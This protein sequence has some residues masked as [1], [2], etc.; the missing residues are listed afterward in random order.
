MDSFDKLE[1]QKD[2]DLI[3]PQDLKLKIINEPLYHFKS[4][5]KLSTCCLCCKDLTYPL[6]VEERAI[7]L[8]MGFIR[9]YSSPNTPSDVYSLCI[10]FVGSKNN[11]EP[12]QLISNTEI[13]KQ[14]R[15][16]F[17]EEY[18]NCDCECYCF[19]YECI[20]CPCSQSKCNCLCEFDDVK[21]CFS[22]L[23]AF[24]VCHITGMKYCDTYQG[25]DGCFQGFALFCRYLIMISLFIAKDIALLNV[26]GNND[27][28]GTL[29]NRESEYVAFDVDVWI[30]VGC[31]SHL[32]I[33]VCILLCSGMVFIGNIGDLDWFLIGHGIVG[34]FL[35]LFTSAWM[36]IGFLL[37][38]EMEN[39]VNNDCKQMVYIWCII[40]VIENVLSLV[41]VCIVYFYIFL[42]ILAIE[43]CADSD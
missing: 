38:S 33:M 4:S 25:S 19:E 22:H 40:Q 26:N 16:A 30:R 13:R 39:D 29:L 34:C 2:E 6:S 11:F 14:K 7:K 31:I 1:S 3:A 42:S 20:C 10:D 9:R 24:C 15:D 36:V 18:C 27:C 35:W 17:Y 41:M 21:E 28:N 12:E 5:K 8:I 23:F 32:V 43:D 37:H